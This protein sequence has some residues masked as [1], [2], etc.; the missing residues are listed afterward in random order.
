[1]DHYLIDLEEIIDDGP[2][3]RPYLLVGS[4]VVVVTMLIF[5]VTR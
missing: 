1:M 4:V 5:F 2:V 3:Y